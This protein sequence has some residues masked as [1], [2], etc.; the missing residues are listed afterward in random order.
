MK[1]L[2]IAAIVAAAA[3]T[4]VKR[5]VGAIVK[6]SSGSVQGHEA[7]WPKGSGV[8]EY[9]GIPYA[10]PPL[11]E[12][13]FAA[14]K[15][16]TGS[17]ALLLRTSDISSIQTTPAFTAY[18]TGM[19]GGSAEDPHKYEEDCLSINVWT[20]PESGEKSKAVLMWIYG[21][22]FAAG[23]SHAPFY[24]GARL[25]AEEDVVV[26]SFNY[27]INIFGF[28]RAPG[29]QDQNH[30]LLDQRLATEWVRDNI[31][32]F[33]GDP[34]RITLFGESAGSAS[35]DFYAYAW[36]QD[37]ITSEE[38][39]CGGRDAGEKTLECMRGKPALD[40]MNVVGKNG[41]PAQTP[42]TPVADNKVVFKDSANRGKAGNFIK[43]PFMV[44]NT[45]NELGIAAAMGGSGGPAMPPLITKLGTDIAF[46][47]PAGKTADARAN[48]KVPTYRY[49]SWACGTTRQLGLTPGSAPDTPEEAKL[50]KNMMGAWAA[51]A[52]DPENGL[53]GERFGWPT[54]N[55]TGG[56]TL[57]RLGFNNQ[58]AW[59]FGPSRQYDNFCG[60]A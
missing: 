12:L 33:G 37:P 13:R 2:A 41:G 58:S 8:S 50:A 55:P 25:A 57:V 44:G 26:V 54:Y 27:R 52:K 29:I 1:S 4:P 11:K 24:N 34:K 60:Q 19:G 23:S 30:G 48:N 46:T 3:A 51:F 59:N 49:R 39:G 40:I 9:L 28:P 32:A 17:M 6:T 22:A 21:G 14:P 5:D 35:V 56:D 20:K 45:D 42:Y 47:C 43:R 16:F 53:K 31:A 18:G 10:M 36:T 38:V 7:S 15:L